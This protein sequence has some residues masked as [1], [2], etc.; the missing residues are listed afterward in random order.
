MS[1]GLT[2]LDL[3]SPYDTGSCTECRTSW[4]QE[5]NPS[6]WLNHIH[7]HRCTNRHRQH[8]AQKSRKTSPSSS[9]STLTANSTTEMQIRTE[10]VLKLHPS[11]INYSKL[12][13]KICQ[14]N[15]SN[16]QKC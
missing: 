9:H 5:D 3:S 16:I 7:C 10:N 2:Q 4:K 8:M 1:K 13:Q 12:V 15:I 14:I 6:A 11:K